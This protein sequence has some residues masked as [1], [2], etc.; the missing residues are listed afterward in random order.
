MDY[1]RNRRDLFWYYARQNFWV[2]LNL[3]WRSFFSIAMPF[4]TTSITY[5]KMKGEPHEWIGWFTSVMLFFC[6]W[7]SPMRNAFIEEHRRKKGE[8]FYVTIRRETLLGS[9]L[10]IWA[11]IYINGIFGIIL[12][13]R[14]FLELV[15]EFG[16]NLKEMKDL[17][18]EGLW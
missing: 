15:L 6:P 9:L 12:G 2:G 16:D 18:D 1:K 14:Y 8:V 7:G 10:L 5:H 3:A 13:W 11:D 17:F 4:V